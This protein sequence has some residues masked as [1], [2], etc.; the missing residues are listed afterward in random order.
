MT[1]D[2]ALAGQDQPCQI[3]SQ[4]DDYESGFQKYGFDEQNYYIP[5]AAERLEVARDFKPPYSSRLRQLKRCPE[6]GRYY[7]YTTDY[8]FLMGSE[9]EQTLE[10]LS[11][12]EAA[13]YLNQP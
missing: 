12:E 9:D 3:C 4:L 1:E 5:A 13:G 7:L 2:S 11:A 10:R 6:C 8:T